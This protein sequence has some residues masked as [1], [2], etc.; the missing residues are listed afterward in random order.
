MISAKI[1]VTPTIDLYNARG[2]LMKILSFIYDDATCRASDGSDRHCAMSATTLLTASWKADS[3]H[4]PPLVHTKEIKRKKVIA[5]DRNIKWLV[6]L[7]ILIKACKLK[8][9]SV[10][11]GGDGWGKIKRISWI[12]QLESKGESPQFELRKL[13]VIYEI[14]E[15]SVLL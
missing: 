10:I 13:L 12:I 4:S 9:P 7:T 15:F 8:Q 6:L 3:S 1:K 5:F 2:P 14:L 11:E